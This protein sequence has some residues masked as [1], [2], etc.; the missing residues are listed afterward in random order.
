MSSLY[1]K[2][3]APNLL[4]LKLTPR[5]I[6]IRRLSNEP[7]SPS[8]KAPPK[9][10]TL[11]M[12][13]FT[14]ICLLAT[15]LGAWQLQRYQWKVGLLDEAEKALHAAAVD[16]PH[17]HQHDL[18]EFATQASGK[19]VSVTGKF[20]HSKEVRLGPRPAPLSL[21]GGA[22]QGMSSSPLGYYIITPLIRD[23]GTIVFVNR[24][25]VSKQEKTW[26]QP[27]GKVTVSAVVSSPEVKPS[28]FTPPNVPST[29]TLFWLEADALKACANR[30]HISSNDVVVVDAFA[31]ND[32]VPKS[33]PV[34]KKAKDLTEQAVS[35][36]T[37]LVY[38]GTW[39]TLA[40]AG[41]VMT[42]SM[43]KK[44]TRRRVKVPTPPTPPK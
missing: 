22:A 37:H 12:T 25:W 21:T 10:D 17:M 13:F 15:G 40:A 29:G 39:F 3:V 36:F 42:Y 1:R 4:G 32:F 24:G 8:A 43:F 7:P 28:S 11:G 41:F 38:A 18:A 33:Y 14:S 27:T 5:G 34:P 44:P 26:S 9:P 6:K 20:D 35:P 23:D 16:L 2:L 30:E 31:S 19:K